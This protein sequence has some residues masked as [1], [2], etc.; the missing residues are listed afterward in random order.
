LKLHGVIEGEK[1]LSLA[2]ERLTGPCFQKPPL[3]AAV[4]RELRIRHIYQ[5][6]MLEFN[7]EENLGIVWVSCEAGTYV[8]VLM[9]HLG[10]MLG[11]GAH[12]EDLR[13]VRSG[14]LSENETLVTMHDLKDA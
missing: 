6:K 9:V 5:L 2:I 13:R 4:K 8:R 14:A 12:M 10:L 3:I 11:V 7:A 1:A